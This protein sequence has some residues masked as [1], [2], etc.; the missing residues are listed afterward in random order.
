MSKV[1]YCIPSARP[2]A[3]VQP[4]VDAWRAMGYRVAL[5]RDEGAEMPACDYWVWQGESPRAGREGAPG[6]GSPYPGYAVAV[7]RLSREVLAFNPN[8]QWIV[9][10]GDDTLPDPNKRADE[11]ADELTA[12][13]GGTFG[14]MQPTGDRFSNGSIDRIAGSPWMGREFCERMYCGNGPLF[15]G[16]QHMFVDEEL[17]HV[18]EKLGV[19]WRRPDLVQLHR[20]FMRQSDDL[21]SP[22]VRKTIPPHLVKWNSQ[23]HWNESKALFNS[24]KDAGFPGHEPLPVEVHA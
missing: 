15:S 8:C 11:I 9:T 10:G 3:E 16:Y 12:H 22:A 2:A 19:Y 21:N 7:N 6:N 20:H 18:A 13:F 1:W 17:L 14:V 24:R 5:W 23:Q 4:V